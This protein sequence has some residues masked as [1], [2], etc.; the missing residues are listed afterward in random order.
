[1][2]KGYLI[3]AVIYSLSLLLLSG[4][5]KD[6]DGKLELKEPKKELSE[7]P[8]RKNWLEM[9]ISDPDKFKK[10]MDGSE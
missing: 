10:Q 6:G 5:Y 2:K 4:C 9:D 1:M 8:E 3:I 7:M